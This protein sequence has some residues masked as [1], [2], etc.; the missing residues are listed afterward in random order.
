MNLWIGRVSYTDAVKMWLGASGHYLDNPPPGCLFAIGVRRLE[1]VLFDDLPVPVGDL[2]GLCLVGRPSAR[3]LPQDGSV[4]EI[5]RMVLLPGLPYG[6]ASEVLKRAIREA[7]ERGMAE[8]IAYHDRTR[9]KGCI[10]KKAGFK[11]AGVTTPSGLGWASRSRPKSATAGAT[12]KR[13]WS[14]KVTP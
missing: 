14:I 2:L 12:S 4:G 1:P 3:M 8:L 6:L 7:A 9:H 11:K 5:T 13:K 10:Y